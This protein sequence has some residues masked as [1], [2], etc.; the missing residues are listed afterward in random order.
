MW[1]APSKA[2]LITD[3]QLTLLSRG[4]ANNRRANFRDGATVSIE[5]SQRLV[6]PVF[7]VVD[8]DTGAGDNARAVCRVIQKKHSLAGQIE[9]IIGAGNLHFARQLARSREVGL[10]AVQRLSGTDQYRLRTSL[11]PADDVEHVV[12]AVDEVDICPARRAE[13]HVG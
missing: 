8:S 3:I 4:A 12:H 9:P 13:H 7:R 1:A 5:E 6:L 11:A 10:P 2:M